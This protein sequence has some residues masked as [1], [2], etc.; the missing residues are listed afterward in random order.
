[1]ATYD[2]NA[3]EPYEIEHELI[4]STAHPQVGLH[5]AGTAAQP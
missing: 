2:S 4:L 5:P 3:G 1:M